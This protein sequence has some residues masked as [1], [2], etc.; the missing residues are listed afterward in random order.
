MSITENSLFV[1]FFLSL[2]LCLKNAAA[3]SALGRACDRLEGWFLRQAENSAICTF[4]WREGHIPRAWPHSIACRLFTAII[5]IPCALFK[6]V[7]RAGKRVWDA[8]LF[9]RLIGALGGASFLFLGLFMMV[10]LMTPHA[11][12]NNVYGLMGA[13]ALTGLFVVGSA[14]RP[15]HRLELDTLGP[16]MTFYMAFICI[17]LAGSLSTRLSLRFFAFHLTGFLLVLL[18]VSMVRKYEQLQLMVA[19]AVLG[20]SVAALYGCY[21][22]Y[23]G[24]DIVASQQDMNL[25]QG[26]PG[27]VYSFF[28]NPNNFAEQL[29]MLLPLNLALF[30]N[31]HWRGK[32]LSLLSLGV[33]LVAI[34]ATYGRASWIGLAGAV[35]VFL[36]LLNWRW[37]PVFLLVGLAAIPF[38]PETIYNRIL[39]IFNAGEDSSVQYRFGIYETTRTLMEDYWARGVGLGT[40][41]MKKVFQTYPTN[42]DGS[43]PVHTHNNY[44][45]LWGEKGI[46]G[47]LAYLSLLL[48]QLKSGVKGF[49]A[50]LDPRVKRMMAAAI[51]AFCGIL[52]IGVAEYTWYYPRNMFTYWFLFGVIGA[53]IKLV[54]MEQDKQAA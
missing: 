6:A 1:R 49:C 34:G 23:I 39:T 4:V 29:A 13:V 43:Y 52:V 33:G 37:V 48:Y 22:S 26:M 30:L 54:R 42:F 2:W 38:L 27:R 3:N 51:G 15:K 14:S 24:V 25:N 21:Q 19:L 31:S 36:A 20:L 47:L 5:N 46:L 53:C 7:Y 35:L 40:D 17:A 10:M 32:L 50:A 44:L 41:V 12:W 18:V 8:S 16:Y 11:M 45:Q 28:D 9:C